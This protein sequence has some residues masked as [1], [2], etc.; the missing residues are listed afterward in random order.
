M[1][2]LTYVATV[3]GDA[4]LLTHGSDPLLTG[5]GLLLDAILAGHLD[6]I[7]GRRVVA[8]QREDG[9]PL[10]CDL[11]ARVLGGAPG[12]PHEWIHRAAAF[13]SHHVACELIAAGVA[14]PLARRFQRQFTLSV[15]ARAEAAARARITEEPALAGLLYARGV[16]T[17]DPL[18]PATHTLPA[19]ARAVLQS[20]RAS[21]G[22]SLAAR[23]AG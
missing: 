1:S 11:R 16:P 5:A 21:A 2:P 22:E 7:E 18:P 4:T 20:V 19:A 14:A 10:L 9:A 6:V 8:A 12:S 17:G 3:R 15:D 13:A 23:L